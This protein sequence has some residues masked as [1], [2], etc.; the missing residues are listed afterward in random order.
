MSEEQLEN[1]TTPLAQ[2]IT[3]WFSKKEWI[4]L[5]AAVVIALGGTTAVALAPKPAPVK[6]E[7]VAVPDEGSDEVQAEEVVAPPATVITE[8]LP[9]T[10]TST[11]ATKAATT[12]T[13]TITPKKKT[14]PAKKPATKKPTPKEPETPVTPLPQGPSIASFGFTARYGTYN[15]KALVWNIVD[16]NDD[17]ILLLSNKVIFSG[18]FKADW[19][20][21]GSSQYKTSDIRAWLND[22]FLK[23]AFTTA[24]SDAIIPRETTGVTDLV[25]LFT[26]QEVTN[27][28]PTPLARKAAATEWA[29]T[30]LGFSGEALTLKDGASSWWLAD[31]TLKVD[32]EAQVVH[33]D[34]ALA[35]EPVYYGDIGVRPAIVLDRS[36]VDLSVGLSAGS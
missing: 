29:R 21:A 23:E 16:L 30:N 8:S 35:S 19:E 22:S 1:T 7:V 33:P 4:V 14:K 11:E 26:S 13:T 6:K 20:S 12:T 24:Q 25:F 34:G 18:A 36:L 3:S 15:N 27:Y 10:Q 5:G 9:T 28:F 2:G 31:A 17:E 32:A